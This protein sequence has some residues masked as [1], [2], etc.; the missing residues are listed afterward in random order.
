MKE[1][2]DLSENDCSKGAKKAFLLE[3]LYYSRMKGVLIY[4]PVREG[5]ET[6]GLSTNS[7]FQSA[8]ENSSDISRYFLGAIEIFFG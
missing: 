4:K 5:E 8:L 6:H 3:G 1:L 2:L 7:N